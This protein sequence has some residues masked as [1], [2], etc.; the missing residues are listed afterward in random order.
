MQAVQKFQGKDLLYFYRFLLKLLLTLL[1]L[2]LL[3]PPFPKLFW[4][5]SP[6]FSAQMKHGFGLGFMPPQGAFDSPKNYG[7]WKC[8]GGPR[9]SDPTQLD[10]ENSG[11]VLELSLIPRPY[12]MAE[13]RR[14]RCCQGHFIPLERKAAEF[15]CQIHCSWNRNDSG[16]CQ[17]TELPLLFQ[18]SGSA[19]FEVAEAGTRLP[20]R[21]AAFIP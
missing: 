13:N 3:F 8:K 9:G 10:L 12:L 20:L 7:C 4:D 21:F 11:M 19:G 17:V 14:W 16:S 15:Q 5:W 6:T 2:S 18:S 1:L